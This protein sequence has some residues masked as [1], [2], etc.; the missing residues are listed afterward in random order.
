LLRCSRCPF[1]Y[2][3]IGRRYT[4]GSATTVNHKVDIGRTLLT[5]GMFIVQQRLQ[6][7]DARAIGSIGVWR[8][9]GPYVNEYFSEL[10][11]LCCLY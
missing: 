5:A 7:C 2:C 10:A 6:L 9:F 4:D 1:S 11:G 3:S 8:D